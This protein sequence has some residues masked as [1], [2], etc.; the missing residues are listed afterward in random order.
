[1]CDLKFVYLK[2]PTDE[3]RVLTIGYCVEELLLGTKKAIRYNFTVNKIVD[4]SNWKLDDRLREFLGNENFNKIQRKFK[5][6]YSGDQHNKKIAKEVIRKK[7]KKHGSYNVYPHYKHDLNI[8][9]ILLILFDIDRKF[10]DWYANRIAKKHYEQI[11]VEVTDEVK[12]NISGGW[13]SVG[14]KI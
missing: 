4:E 14:E 7:F 12:S 3:R 11:L 10:R 13:T 2:D 9:P 5:K 6:R 1:M 8:K